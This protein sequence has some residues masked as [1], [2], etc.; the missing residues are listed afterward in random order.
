MTAI[1]FTGLFGL[2]LVMDITQLDMRLVAFVVL[3]IVFIPIQTRHQEW[4][5]VLLY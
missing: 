5:T 1:G 4:I 2:V 3:T